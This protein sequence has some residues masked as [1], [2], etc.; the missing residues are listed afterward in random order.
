MRYMSSSKSKDVMKTLCFFLSGMRIRCSNSPCTV[1]IPDYWISITDF[2][3]L[4]QFPIWM[5]KYCLYLK[6]WYFICYVLFG[7]D[8]VF[9][10]IALKYFLSWLL[11]FLVPPKLC[12]L[13]E[14][15]TN[16]GS[17]FSQFSGIFNFPISRS[18]YYIKGDK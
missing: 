12:T 10:I 15:L 7:S 13:K 4:P 2:F 16:V 9:L 8:D 6:Y 17:A 3:L 1:K 14:C 18:S 11:N 5:Y